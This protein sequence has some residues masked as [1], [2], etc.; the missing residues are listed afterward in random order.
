MTKNN[1]IKDV[2]D[3]VWSDSDKMKNVHKDRMKL[4]GMVRG[5]GRYFT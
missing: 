5:F 2:W 3:K 4:L 1:V